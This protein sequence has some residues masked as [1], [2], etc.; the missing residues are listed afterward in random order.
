V[1]SDGFTEQERQQKEPDQIQ[2]EPEREEGSKQSVSG[3][4]GAIDQP[5]K[6]TT[7]P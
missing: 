3:R 4:S 5:G 2:V 1:E 7:A 6:R